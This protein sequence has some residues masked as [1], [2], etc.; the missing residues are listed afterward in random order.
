MCKIQALSDLHGYLPKVPPCDLFLLAGDVLPDYKYRADQIAY[1]RGPFREW[2][3]T[4][5]A[6]EVVWIGGNHDFALQNRS[7]GLLEGF[8]GHYLQ[9][10]GVTLFGK[11]IWGTPW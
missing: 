10:S 4:L 9:D 7:E 8:R 5:P 3:N 2:L 1:V 6:Q 11:R